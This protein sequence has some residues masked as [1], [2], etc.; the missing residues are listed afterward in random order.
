MTKPGKPLIHRI[1]WSQR[2]R[3]DL[4]AIHAY[5]ELQAPLAA[6]RLAAALVATAESLA[7]HPKRG[8][9]LYGAVREVVVIRPY[10]IRYRVTPDA[11]QIMR[12]KHGAQI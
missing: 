11:V 1:E 10:L 2:S 12:V 8:R 9:P 7:T 4:E 5:V 6:A 3:R